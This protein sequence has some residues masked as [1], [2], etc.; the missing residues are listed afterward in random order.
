ARDE[1]VIAAELFRAPYAE[2]LRELARL[3]RAFGGRADADAEQ[4]GRGRPIERAAQ[5]RGGLVGDHR[6]LG[7]ERANVDIAARLLALRALRAR[8]EALGLREERRGD[9]LAAC[10]IVRHAVGGGTDQDVDRVDQLTQ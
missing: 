9:A 8:D 1:R 4:R 2:R 6:D 10:R 5:L 3:R 7:D